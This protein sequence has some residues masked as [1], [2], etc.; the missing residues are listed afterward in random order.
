MWSLHLTP[1]EYS[2]IEIETILD[3]KFDN[4]SHLTYLIVIIN[5]PSIA[6]MMN[7]DLG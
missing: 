3:L 1:T 6:L 5:K 4:S 7:K 2:V